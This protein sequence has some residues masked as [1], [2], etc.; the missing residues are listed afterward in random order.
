MI[1]CCEALLWF[2]ENCSKQNKQNTLLLHPLCTVHSLR[3]VEVLV[4]MVSINSFHFKAPDV[5]TF[6]ITQRVIVIL[7]LTQVIYIKHRQNYIIDY[8][9]PLIWNVLVWCSAFTCRHDD[10]MSRCWSFYHQNPA[11]DDTSKLIIANTC[12]NP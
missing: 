5:A 7:D 6:F 9:M 2:C 8:K 4:N 1:S 3:A 12:A 10:G 11:S